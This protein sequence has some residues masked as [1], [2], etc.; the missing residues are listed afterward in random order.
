MTNYDDA[1]AAVDAGA[2]AL[3]FVFVRESPRY[4]STEDAA[5][6][7]RR[8][9]PFITTAGVFVNEQPAVAEQVAAAAGLAVLQLHG[10]ETPDYCRSVSST[11][12]KSFRVRT[13]ESLDPFGQYQDIVSA[14]LLDAYSPEAYGGT[15]KT[16]NWDIAVEAKRYGRVVLA[17]GLTV[18]NVADAVAHVRPYA[19][20]VSS[21]V[22][23]AR[24]K[25][26]HVLLRLFIER[27]KAVK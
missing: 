12:I 7:I 16:F 19:V 27:A 2:D 15:G 6:I 17:G 18:D 20:D 5:A 8:L 22:E 1:A 4:I 25:K 13:L 11:V 9:P 14:Y 10:E 21:G 24:G 23:Q 3:G 26:D